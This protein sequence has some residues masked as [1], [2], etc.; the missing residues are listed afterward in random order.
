[1]GTYVFIRQQNTE[2]T[3][4]Y[5]LQ[6]DEFQTYQ[7][8]LKLSQEISLDGCD[9]YIYFENKYHVLT[10]FFYDY[11]SAKKVLEK[12][13]INYS[14]ASIFSIESKR[15]SKQKELNKYLISGIISVIIFQQIQ[16]IGMNIGILP[17][18]GVTLPF[19]SYG[20]SSLISYMI[21]IG[22]IFNINKKKTT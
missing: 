11:D 3:E 8:A 13:K 10:R 20:G 2:I 18:T 22:L 16:N 6:I 1:M 5:F 14:S 15:F 7:Q 17:I 19:I 12:T 21:L 9:S 4:L